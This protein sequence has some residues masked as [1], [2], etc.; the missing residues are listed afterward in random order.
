MTPAFDRA[1]AALETALDGPLRGAV[2][3]AAGRQP[4]MARAVAYLVERMRAHAWRAGDVD[5]GLRDVVEDLDR[6]TRREGFHV[7]HDWNGKADAV[8]ENTIAI[9]AAEYAS[10]LIGDRP[11]G[12]DALA[13]ALD[14]YFL[15][16][17]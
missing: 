5:I 15:Y 1:C 7:L 3:G 12:G 17:L 4:T 16:L 8:T 9:D 11:V 6:A 2:A 14:Y 13:L 10:G